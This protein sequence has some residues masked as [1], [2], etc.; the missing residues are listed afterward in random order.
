MTKENKEKLTKFLKEQGT[1][2][3]ILLTT[4]RILH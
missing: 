4:T 1:N 3:M 2:I